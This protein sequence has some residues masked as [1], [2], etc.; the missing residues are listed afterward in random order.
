MLPTPTVTATMIEC[1]GFAMILGGMGW[2]M[3]KANEAR[4]K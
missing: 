2:I 1:A 3:W 4:T